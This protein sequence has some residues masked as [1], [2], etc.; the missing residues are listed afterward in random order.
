MTLWDMPS[1]GDTVTLGDM[2]LGDTV[3]LG[4]HAPHNYHIPNIIV[5]LNATV[6]SQQK[7]GVRSSLGSRGEGVVGRA[8]LSRNRHTAGECIPL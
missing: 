6:S 2:T 3:T 4:N 1:L 5:S 8:T 7:G